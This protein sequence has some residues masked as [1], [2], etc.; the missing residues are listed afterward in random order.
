MIYDKRVMC[1]YL[2]QQFFV[3][4]FTLSTMWICVL[5]STHRTRVYL[6]TKPLELIK[7]IINNSSILKL[8]LVHY[9][10]L[11]DLLFLSRRLWNH[12]SPF[13]SS[14]MVGC[15]IEHGGTCP[16][17]PFLKANVKPLIWPL[18]KSKDITQ[19]LLLLINLRYYF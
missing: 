11:F 12:Y 16:F 2:F 4:P 13:R 19:N 3:I 7:R 5:S 15:W 6:N 9:C 10:F 17:S 1:S 18:V 14:S 8:W